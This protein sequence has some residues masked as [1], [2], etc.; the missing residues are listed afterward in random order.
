[1]VQR[2]SPESKRFLREREVLEILSISKATLWR[3]IHKGLFPPPVRISERVS[4]WR[5]EDV[6]AWDPGVPHDQN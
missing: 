3:L 5:A 4:R 6:M 1:V 2:V